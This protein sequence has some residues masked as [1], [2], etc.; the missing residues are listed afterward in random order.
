[1]TQ[2]LQ[3]TLNIW[4]FQHVG[5]EDL[6]SLEQVL[7][8]MGADIRYICGRRESLKVL[9]PK[10]P[11]VLI[12]L[13]GPMGLY[14]TDE[15]P[16]LL[17]EVELVK[18]RIELDLPTLG[19]CLG[20]Q[21]IAKALGANVYKGAQGQEIGFHHINVN[22]QGLKT[23]LRHLDGAM[24]QMMHWHSD[25][26]D[27][28][29]DVTHLAESDLYKNQAYKY[30]NNVMAVQC[31]PEI[32]EKK[33]ALW[34]DKDRADLDEIPGLTVEKILDDASQYGQI[35]KSQA[36]LFL[37]EWLEQVVPDKMAVIQAR[38]NIEIKRQEA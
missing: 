38:D 28:P 6:G 8:D 19:I 14:E 23:P 13:G 34:V 7:L 16:Y 11:D 31:H 25:T 9:D 5:Y 22:H 37:T 29:E 35:L 33:L 21:I 4:A 17:D 27:L 2:N 12:I 15:Y 36:R 20:A 18:K 10:K 30:K 1:M 32:S 26:F 24:T 3:S